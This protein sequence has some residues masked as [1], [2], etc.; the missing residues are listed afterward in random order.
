MAFQ[1]RLAGGVGWRPGP[2]Q[3]ERAAHRT[4]ASAASCGVPEETPGSWRGSLELGAPR[5]PR[6]RGAPAA[7]TGG[8]R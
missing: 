4:Q 7:P 8:T 2:R 5:E 6:E 3:A 1:G